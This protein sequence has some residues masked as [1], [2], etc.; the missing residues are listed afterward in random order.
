ALVLQQDDN[1]NADALPQS[2]EGMTGDSMTGNLFF[3]SQFSA[4]E[5]FL[6]GWPQ[7]EMNGLIREVTPDGFYRIRSQMADRAVATIFLQSG[8]YDDL[9]IQI[10]AQLDSQSAAASGYGI[11]FNYVDNDNYNVFAVDGLG[12]FSIWVREAGQWRELRGE[13]EQ[14]TLNPAINP[15]GEMNTLTVSVMGNQLTGMVNG[16]T[17][18]TVMDTTLEKGGIGIYI[19]TPPDGSADVLIDMVQTMN[20]LPS[21]SDSM[22]GN[23]QGEVTLEAS[24][25]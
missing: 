18:T 24:N 3:A 25:N 20:T 2:V 1:N 6:A 19:A 11:I 23:Q 14:W 5:P 15:A 8:N 21:L 9:A 12:R 4:D 13:S 7:D 16:E 17:V 10:S 22:T